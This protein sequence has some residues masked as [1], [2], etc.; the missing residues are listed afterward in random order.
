MSATPTPVERIPTIVNELRDYFNSGA[1]KSLKWRQSQ[2]KG[3]IKLLN[4]N[5]QAWVDAM[6][7]DMGSHHFEAALL[8]ANVVSDIEHTL[9]NLE[10]WLQP[11]KFSNP[12]ALYPGSTTVAPEPYGVVLDF[13]PYNYPMYLG[14]STI[15]PILACGNVCLFKPSSK[16]P[17]CAK[18]YQDLFPKYLDPKGTVVVCGPTAICDDILKQR[19]DFIF[20][21]GSPAVA[22]TIM[23]AASEHLTPTLLELGGKSPVYVD[24]SLSM[25]KCCKR[26]VW[27]KFFNGGQTC[28]CPDYVLVNEKVWDSF[29][30]T[31]V[32]AIKELYGDVSEYNDNI[33]H[34]ICKQHF[35]RIVRAIETSNGNKL[36]EGF[37]DASRLY[38]GPTVIESPALDSQLMTEEIFGPVLPLIKVKD[39]KEAIQ[40]INQREKPLALYVLSDNNKTLDLFVRNTSSGAIMMN[41]T[42]FHVSSPFCP[43][44]GVGN[45]GM[46]QYHGKY[47]IRALSHN[48][49]VITHGTMIDLDI[50]Y[51]PYTDS[52]LSLLKKFA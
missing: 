36:V 16:T 8:I 44:G 14:F 31:L 39:A 22:K 35:D 30:E 20:Y 49:P 13:I 15:A 3:L 32:Q 7:S 1:T 2:L 38:I 46:G 10:K 12:W 52:H 33:T 42:T 48:K 34:I 18:L 40:F 19:F 4:E 29:K 47:G 23:R 43:F 5:S 37:R 6:N 25:M 28:V 45:S 24:N 27:G 9:K 51:P 26:L 50:R 41:D 17:A 21:T 11:K